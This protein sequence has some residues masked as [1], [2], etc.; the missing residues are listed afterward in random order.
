MGFLSFTAWQYAAAGAILASGPLIIHLLNRRRYRVLKWAAMDFLRKALEKNRRILQIRDI[1]L[2]ILRTAAVLLFGLAVAR[3]YFARRQ[4]QFDD[5]QPLHA[6]IVIDNSLSMAYESLEGT[7]LDK[8]KDRARGLID[9]LPT[10]SRISI[11]PACGSRDGYSP[12][13][14][15]TKDNAGEA[16]DKIEVVD[17]SASTLRIINE[18]RRACETASDLA[19]RI[20]LIGDQ[21]SL[22]WRDVRQN[23]ALRD[24]PPMQVVSVATPEAENTWISDLRVQDG[25]VDVETPATVIVELRHRGSG[26]RRDLVVTL[27]MGETVVGEKTVTV[28]P[29]LGTREVDFE[30]T[31]SALE[32]LPEPGRPIFVPIRA[33]IAPDRLAADDERHLAVPVVAALPVVFIDQYSPEQESVVQGRLGETRHLRNLLAP[34]TSRSEAPRQLINVRHLTA[35]G[36]T[37]EILADA[38]LVIVAGLRDPASMTPLLRDFVRQGGQ[39][40]VAAG[41]DFDPA[42]WNDAGWLDGDGILPLPLAAEPLGQTPEVGGERLKPF[43]LAFESLANEPYFQLAGVAESD[44][45]DLYTEPFFFKAVRVD[46]SAA[47][48]AAWKQHEAQAIEEELRLTASVR[49]LRDELAAKEAQG[50]VS[51]QDRQL[52]RDEEAKLRELRP[53]WLVWAAA[54]RKEFT[55]EAEGDE[56]LEQL[57]E[58]TERLLLAR[59]PRVLARFD[60]PGRPAFLA[61]RRLGGGEVMFCSTGLL[62][63]WNTLPKTNAVLIF[64]R[65]LRAMIQN[66]LPRRNFPAMERLVLPL[67]AEE[68]NL[69]VSL[70]RPGQK[71]IPEPLDVGYIGN[72]LRGVTLTALYQRGVYRVTGARPALTADHATAAPEKPVWDVPLVVNGEADESDVTPLERDQFAEMAANGNLRWVAPGEEISLAGTAIS[73]QSSWWW[74]MF[75]VFALLIVEMSVLAWPTMSP[76]ESIFATN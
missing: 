12:D 64:D 57:Q 27:H 36:V 73:G 65:I 31:F 69:L 60:L 21:Q 24:M 38:R 55:L 40:L 10:G 25:L 46:D 15:E 71:Q 26:P 23:E 66:T 74:L 51:A 49:K 53:A 37:Q 67:P 63:S 76:G 70:A 28:E 58:E 1:L 59:A 34:R 6:V 61:S 39:L 47:A 48:L 42:S 43:F 68:Q 72:D 3:P 75:T 35:G 9:K 56:D 32:K 14:Y 18:V 41:A 45:R 7:L 29:G 19:K 33:S 17:R 2:L 52:L 54:E 22:N 11:I 5:R 20:V 8:A 16:L 30:W 50:D 44:L 13:P 4:E 62:S